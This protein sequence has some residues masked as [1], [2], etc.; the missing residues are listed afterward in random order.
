MTLSQTLPYAVAALVAGVLTL[1]DLDRTFY[2]SSVIRRKVALNLW[3]WGFIII[4]GVLAGFL[5][6]L[7]QEQPPLKDIAEPIRAILVGLG[8][9]ALV[10]TK[11]TTFTIQGQNVAL[12]LEPA[13]EGAKEYFFKRINRIALDASVEECEAMAN[14]FTLSQLQLRADD[15]IRHDRLLGAG[16]HAAYEWVE[17]VVGDNGS[18]EVVKKRVLAYFILSGNQPTLRPSGHAPELPKPVVS[19]PSAVLHA[20]SS[21]QTQ[22]TPQ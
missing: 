4:N 3:W 16:Q 14:K 20:E 17:R 19:Q 1:F 7:L 15:Y 10:R 11:F 18:E 12:G 8:Y 9:L 5:Y 2:I 22:E 13:Y 6:A 21:G